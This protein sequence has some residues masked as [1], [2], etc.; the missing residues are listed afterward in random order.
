M[1]NNTTFLPSIIHKL[2]FEGKEKEIIQLIKLKPNIIH[3]VDDSNQTAA[4]IAAIKGDV[5]L[6]EIFIDAGVDINSKD[7]NEFS[8]LHRAVESN[9]FF[10][11]SLLVNKFSFHFYY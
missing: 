5:K 1:N 8:L 3:H 4:H 9:S 10:I 7:E 11:V 2:T 6:M